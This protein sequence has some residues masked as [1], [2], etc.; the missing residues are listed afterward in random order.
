[1]TRFLNII[2]VSLI[3]LFAC[4]KEIHPDLE[5]PAN[6]IVIDAW[7]TD[8]DTIQNIHVTRSQPYFDNA[9][10]SKISGATV[11]VY[12]QDNNVFPFIENDSTYTWIS[13]DGQPFGQVGNIY[14]LVVEVNGEQFEA[15]SDMGRVPPID[16]INF[17]FEE[18]DAF[19]TQDFYLAEF[20]S[21]DP[22]GVG[23]TYWIK[24]WK[25][26]QLLNKPD[27]INVAWDAAFTEGGGV[28]GQV[29]IQ[30][31]QYAINPIDEDPDQD[32]EFIPPYDIGDSVYVEIHSINVHAFYFLQEVLIQT[33]R[34]GGFGALFATP[35]ANVTTNVY[36][37]NGNSGSSVFGF[38]NVAAVSSAGRRL[39]EEV[40]LAAQEEARNSN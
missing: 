6:A 32:N 30:P 37:T 40:A 34:E 24:A 29:F 13:P 16:S 35:L 33:N 23:D 8:Q 25:N 11:N 19:I 4:E 28:D 3:F 5:S 26:G 18:K 38:F 15:V 17:K 20:V 22:E 21:R 12:D 27:E 39:T 9:S 7:L 14:F 2:T 10:P 31:I 36:N 1:M